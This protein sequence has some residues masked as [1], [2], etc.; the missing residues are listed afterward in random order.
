M[1][2]RALGPQ[3]SEVDRLD[4]IRE[5]DVLRVSHPDRTKGR[6]VETPVERYVNPDYPDEPGHLMIKVYPE[7]PEGA[8][9]YSQYSMPPGEHTPGLTVHSIRRPR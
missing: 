5:G 7:H 4:D 6:V 2:H 8:W 1:S 9:D 3:F